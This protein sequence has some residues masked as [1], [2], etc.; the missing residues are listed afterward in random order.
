MAGYALSKQNPITMHHI[1]P[2]LQGGKTTLENGSNI[3]N[4]AH[5]GIHIIS[6]DNYYNAQFI[7]DYLLYYKEFRDNKARLMFAKWL[8]SELIKLECVETLTQDNLLMY[9]RRR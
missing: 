5:T 1:I 4:L 2:I 3:S 7:V 6:D 9:K 8:K